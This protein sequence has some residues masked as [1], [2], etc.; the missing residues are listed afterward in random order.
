MEYA[1]EDFGKRAESRALLTEEQM[2]ALEERISDS[3]DVASYGVSKLT[4]AINEGRELA[5]T[6][7]K[8]SAAARNDLA[9][10]NAALNAGLQEARTRDQATLASLQA[11]IAALE[12]RITG[13]LPSAASM[14]LPMQPRAPP[15]PAPEPQAPR[16][17]P[18]PSQSSQAPRSVYT[19]PVDPP[20]AYRPPGRDDSRPARDTRSAAHEYSNMSY[21]RNRSP[22]PA[23]AYAQKKRMVD[24]PTAC[25]PVAAPPVPVPTT[26]AVIIG[27][28]PELDSEQPAATLVQWVVTLLP[29]TEHGFSRDIV[30]QVR[31]GLHIR[32]TMTSPEAASRLVAHWNE[33]KP[34]A[35]TN[36]LLSIRRSTAR[37]DAYT[38]LFGSGN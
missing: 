8:A 22:P 16:A 7:I 17:G 14:L 1:Q 31:Q 10:T 37:D 21:K 18:L 13:A 30:S 29:L 24:P 12:L 33:H 32:V 35:G 11:T 5:N 23:T 25:A 38:N 9:A 20:A 15:Q 34:L 36:E 27:P 3:Q 4:G 6:A 2:K 28:I 26:N 19:R